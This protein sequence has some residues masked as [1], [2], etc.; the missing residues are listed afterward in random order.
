MSKHW[1][2]I[3]HIAK[4]SQ[5]KRFLSSSAESLLGNKSNIPAP[6]TSPR[7]YSQVQNNK[8]NTIKFLVRELSIMGPLNS[9]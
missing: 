3:G 9:L 7:S 6:N 1:L 2:T 5:E 8:F 4:D